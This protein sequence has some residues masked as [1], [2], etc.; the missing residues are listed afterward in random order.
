MPGFIV[1]TIGG[2]P[3][4]P[5]TGANQEYFYKYSWSIEYLFAESLLGGRFTSRGRFVD[6]SPAIQLRDATLPTFTANKEVVMGSSVEYKFAKSVTFD[7]VK[8]TWY[9][10]NGLLDIM[11]EWRALVWNPTDGLQTARTYK[12]RSEI[13]QFLPHDPSEVNRHILINSWPSVIRHGELTYTESEVNLVEVTITYD[14]S[15]GPS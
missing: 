7:D 11:R 10:T 6:N 8:V 9:D 2:T 5:N 4:F 12:R 14:W 1:N 13:Q 3:G 15:R